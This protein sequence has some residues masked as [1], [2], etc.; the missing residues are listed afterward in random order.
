MEI[1]L[2][3]ITCKEFS[4]L[5]Q[6]YKDSLMKN[7]YFESSYTKKPNINR[8]LIIVFV[9]LLIYL[10]TTTYWSRLYPL[11]FLV[12]II[13]YFIFQDIQT[14]LR[15]KKLGKDGIFIDE[16]YFFYL[17]KDNLIILP[18]SEFIN[19]EIIS[20]SKSSFYTCFN[21]INDKIKVACLIDD[22]EFNKFQNAISLN[23]KFS[24]SNSNSF[25]LLNQKKI[26]KKIPINS[27]SLLFALIIVFFIQFTIPIIIDK[28]NYQKA[29]KINTATSY[30]NYLKESKNL[31]YRDIVK[32]E[33]KY[34]YNKHIDYYL[35]LS[36][37]ST[38]SDVFKILLEYLRD[39]DIYTVQIIFTPKSNINDIC[40]DRFKIIPITP[41]FSDEENQKRQ[42]SSIKTLQSTLGKIFPTDIIDFSNLSTTDLSLP[43]FVINYTYTND[44]NSLYYSKK[45]EN[46]S[47][48]LRTYYYGITI[49]WDIK[50]FIDNSSIP[51][52]NFELLSNPAQEFSSYN[53]DDVY[54]NMAISAF[55][56][57]KREFSN[58]F[59]TTK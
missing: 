37:S 59:L 45:E 30:R 28:N 52:Y 26:F 39:N 51:I 29:K 14:Y 35:N 3:K 53:V 8:I 33:I 13:S 40:S 49:V 36:S 15:W 41:S 54:S 5:K 42:N 46:L 31:N 23:S 57:F 48:E 24:K 32:D 34:L 25:L 38:G 58:H 43:R 47:E 12:S 1:K 2:R 6:K 44:P 22:D 56:D 11:T 55:N 20:S 27:S 17:K 16:N 7:L 21:F 9:I 19:S 18:L 10:F 4:W 50:L